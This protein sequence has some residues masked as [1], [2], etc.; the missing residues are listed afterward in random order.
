[1]DELHGNDVRIRFIGDRRAFSG[2]LQEGMSEAEEKTAAN[3]RMT[4]CIAVN[5]GGQWDIAH[6]ARQLASQVAAGELFPWRT[7][8]V[9]IC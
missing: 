5:Y 6:A 9:L 8:R 7:C 4:V 2:D 3:Q 1:M